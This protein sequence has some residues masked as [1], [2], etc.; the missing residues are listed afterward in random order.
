MKRPLAGNLRL[1]PTLWHRLRRSQ[2]GGVAMVE[3]ALL[4]AFVAA[5]LISGL[6]LFKFLYVDAATTLSADSASASAS[7]SEPPPDWTPIAT[8]SG[9]PMTLIETVDEEG[10]LTSSVLSQLDPAGALTAMMIISGAGVL[11][12][13]HADGSFVFEAPPSRGVTVITFD[14]T[15]DELPVAATS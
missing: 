4:M 7:V 13:W 10:L 1:P 2:D 12:Y 15:Q 8:P 5:A 11:V 6:A 9:Q 3:Y 14:Y